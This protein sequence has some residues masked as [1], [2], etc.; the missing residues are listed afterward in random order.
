MQPMFYL[1]LSEQLHNGT[2]LLCTA[3]GGSAQRSP[4]SKKGGSEAG[5]DCV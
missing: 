2:P 1:G 5:R 4:D 3:S